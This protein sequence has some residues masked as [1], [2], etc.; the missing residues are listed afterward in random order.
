MLKL[1]QEQFHSEHSNTYC[2]SSLT[3]Q[4][5]QSCFKV[6][7]YPRSSFYWQNSGIE[8]VTKLISD[9]NILNISY[10]QMVLQL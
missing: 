6:T 8:K 9:R 5:P 3:L 1:R 10:P 4:F 7:L 2:N